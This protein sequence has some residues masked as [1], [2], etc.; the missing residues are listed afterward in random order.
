MVCERNLQNPDE[1]NLALRDFN[2]NVGRWIDGCEG[3]HGGNGIGERNV[4]EGDYLSFAINRGYLRQSPGFKRAE[5]NNTQLGGNK[6]IIDFA[7]AGKNN[8]NVKAIP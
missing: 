3:V 7:F 2:R 8:R 1:M 4:R 5:E 6:T